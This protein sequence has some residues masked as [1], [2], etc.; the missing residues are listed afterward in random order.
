MFGSSV[1]E[2]ALG[3]VR[4]LDLSL[5]LPGP[6]ATMLLAA[7]GAEIVKVEPPGGDP[8]RTIDPPMFERVNAGK[9]TREI[10]LRSE[11][12]RGE[13]REL[14]AGC[15]VLIEGFRP[16][17]AERLGFAYDDVVAVRPDVVYCSI[18][19]YGQ[20]GPYRLLPGHDL[21]YL[22][23]AGAAG[24]HGAP[25]PEE[26]DIP[27]VD[28]AT[29]TSAALSVVAA[30]R[31]RDRTGQG[32]YLD[33]AM[34]DSAVAWANV[35]VPPEADADEPAYAVVAAADGLRLSIGVIEDKFWRALCAGLGWADWL[36]EPA[37]ATY[38]GRRAHAPEVHE[39]LER[40]IATR[41]RAHWLAALEAA[42]VPVA[43]VHERHE[44]AGDPQVAEREL[45]IDGR[46]R[47]PLPDA[48]V[49]GRS[50]VA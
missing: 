3:D 18:S 39:R 40:T 38:Q 13:L 29:G 31:R 32:C 24:A 49:V 45:L 12:G 43:P 14:A 41:P 20:S 6:Y 47:A 8:A 37:L 46:I 1:E 21:N 25:G 16:G 36:D 44:V 10:D 4:V 34:L 2:A 9:A 33:V 28:L 26:Q 7:L 19:G 35:K 22:G 27:M 5:Q 42:D 23:V 48:V 15:D 30:I 50:G 11:Q 17:V